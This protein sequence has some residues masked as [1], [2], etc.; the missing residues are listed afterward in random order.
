MQRSGGVRMNRQQ[1]RAAERA[2]KKRH[3]PVLPRDLVGKRGT[4]DCVIAMHNENSPQE[5]VACAKGCSWCCRGILP[6]AWPE[7]IDRIVP[8]VTDGHRERLIAT[9]ALD[10]DRYWRER[11][12][13]AFLVDGAC[14]IYDERPLMCRQWVSVDADACE[15]SYVR[16]TLG[17]AGDVMNDDVGVPI[18]AVMEVMKD[19]IIVNMGK[20]AE[21]LDV[22]ILR[23]LGVA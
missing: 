2:L 18:P 6:H 15:Q 13:C 17:Y 1:R 16:K 3:L 22:A 4:I 10:D 5:Q 11:T 8:L 9:A 23:K 19:T 14:S 12:A 7:E 21:R 20:G